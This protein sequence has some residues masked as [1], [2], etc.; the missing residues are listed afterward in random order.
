[1][2]YPEGIKLAE[3]YF[4]DLVSRKGGDYYRVALRAS[5]WR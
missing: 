2:L 5:C 3:A 4:Y 1:M